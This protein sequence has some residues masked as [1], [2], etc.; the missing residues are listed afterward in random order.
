MDGG[1]VIR[2]H[3]DPDGRGKLTGRNAV[4]AFRETGRNAVKAFRETG[5]CEHDTARQPATS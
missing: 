4:K 1:T 5:V 2:S 3:D